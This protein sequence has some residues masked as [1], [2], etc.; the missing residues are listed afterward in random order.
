MINPIIKQLYKR[1]FLVHMQIVFVVIF[2]FNFSACSDKDVRKFKSNADIEKVDGSYNVVFD[3]NS[4]YE[5]KYLD[6]DSIAI[7]DGDRVLLCG[8]AS[9]DP[10]K[11][12][13][14]Y[15]IA[16]GTMELKKEFGNWYDGEFRK[17]RVN[18]IDKSRTL[19]RNLLSAKEAWDEY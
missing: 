3:R 8:T 15:L 6:V 16:G 1:S 14:W 19:Y 7:S 10:K 13:K 18:D 12:K 5:W 4:E 9:L 2:C 17:Y 11:E